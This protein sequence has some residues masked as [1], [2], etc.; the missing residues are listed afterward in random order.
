MKRYLLVNFMACWKFH[1]PL[2]YL[3]WRTSSSLQHIFCIRPWIHGQRSWSKEEKGLENDVFED[4]ALGHFPLNQWHRPSLPGSNSWATRLRSCT[5]HWC[6]SCMHGADLK[7]RQ[8]IRRRPRIHW[9]HYAFGCPFLMGWC[10]LA[11]N[12]ISMLDSMLLL[13]SVCVFLLGAHWITMT[14]HR[15]LCQKSIEAFGIC[16]WDRQYDKAAIKDPIRDIYKPLVSPKTCSC[17]FMWLHINADLLK[18]TE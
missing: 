13:C 7:R 2:R 6:S 17:E 5:L 11:L 1:W 18:N 3:L 10:C 15:R 8:I 14:F 4:Q 9:L 16:R 12:R